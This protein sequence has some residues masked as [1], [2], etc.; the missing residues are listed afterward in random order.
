MPNILVG[1]QAVLEG[2]MMRAPG[3]MTIAVRRRNGNIQ[4]Q[5]N[6]LKSMDDR[7]RI[8]KKPFFRGFFAL[9]QALILGFRAL[10][11]SSAV[12]M[13]DL[14]NEAANVQTEP[15]EDTLKSESMSTWSVIGVITFTAILGIGF[16]FLLPLYL[17]NLIGRLI[18]EILASTLLF[19]FVDGLIRVIFLV[20]YIFSISLFK[21]IRRVFQYH[22]AEHKA[23]LTYEAGFPL[24]LENAMRFRTLHPRCGTAFLIM[25]MIVAMLI[26]SLIPSAFPLWQKAVVRVILLPI[27]AGLSFELIKKAGETKH[28]FFQLMIKPG[29][30]LQTI[31]TREPDEQQLEVG[32]EALRIALQKSKSIKDDLI[33]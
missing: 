31:T 22:G 18:P 15:K 20:L 12:A 29:L 5:N 14:E 11:F 28:W 21:D 19:N 23:I 17:T 7:L 8:W 27:I 30:W 32:L 24:T 4:V 6:D 26:F 2:V 3:V 16:F 1:G 33:I 25:V 10:N 9:G 13:A